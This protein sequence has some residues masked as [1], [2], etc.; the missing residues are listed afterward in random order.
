MFEKYIRSFVHTQY[1]SYIKANQSVRASGQLNSVF[2]C[3]TFPI[4]IEIFHL[5]NDQMDTLD[6]EACYMDVDSN[7]LNYYQIEK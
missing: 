4:N 6:L 3:I 1:T 7:E 2:S 5:Y